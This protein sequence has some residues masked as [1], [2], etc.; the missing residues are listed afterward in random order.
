[1]Y[2]EEAVEI[3]LVED[4]EA[5]AEIVLEALEEHRIL[6]RTHHVSDGALALDYLF[7][8]GEY[9]EDREHPRPH[10]ILLDLRLPKV[11][12]LEVLKSIK[13]TEDLKD[14]PVIVLTS[15]EAE[16]DMAKAYAYRANSYITK[17]VDFDKFLELM[18]YLGFYWLCLNKTI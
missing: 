6:N 2:P 15:S 10:V 8:R 3:L 1:M 17:P 7:G 12:G 4:N 5:H 13:E 9:A 16:K 14:I 11:D 18:D